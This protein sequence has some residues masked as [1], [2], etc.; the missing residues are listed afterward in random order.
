MKLQKSVIKWNIAYHF[1][2]WQ[3]K[4]LCGIVKKKFLIETYSILTWFFGFNIL[5][6]KDRRS[7]RKIRISSSVPE[8]SREQKNL[9]ELEKV[10][11]FSLRT[12][13]TNILLACTKPFPLTDNSVKLGNC[14]RLLEQLEEQK[15]A[16]R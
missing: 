14:A 5:E 7:H 6:N 10:L 13:N 4:F 1:V 12:W 16:F 9:S 2:I 15:V 3:E 8:K 11:L